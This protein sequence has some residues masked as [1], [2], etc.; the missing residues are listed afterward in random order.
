MKIDRIRSAL[1]VKGIADYIKDKQARK[2]TLFSIQPNGCFYFHEGERIGVD[3]FN[4][5]YPA[6][7]ESAMYKGD[8]P[9]GTK[10]K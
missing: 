2:T 9:D 10:I 1:K 5:L 3:E 8:N 7:L 6:V 4:E